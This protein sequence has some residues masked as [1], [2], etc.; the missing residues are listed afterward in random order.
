M[1][2]GGEGY[3]G[4]EDAGVRGRTG[5]TLDAGG[6]GGREAGLCRHQHS[7]GKWLLHVLSGPE[8]D[9]VGVDEAGQKKGASSRRMEV[10]GHIPHQ[11]LVRKA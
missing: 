3:R 6:G 2:G 4:H 11:I 8:G 7:S 9:E 10:P 5:A 1:W